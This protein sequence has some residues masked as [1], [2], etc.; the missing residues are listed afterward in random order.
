MADVLQPGDELRASGY[1]LYS[2]ACMLVVSVRRSGTRVVRGFT[3]DP[4]T[5]ERKRERKRERERERDDDDA[6]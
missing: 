3:L 2:S 4:T 5:G 6:L 1:L